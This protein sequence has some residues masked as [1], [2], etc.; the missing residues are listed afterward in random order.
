MTYSRIARALSIPRSV[1]NSVHEWIWSNGTI[2]IGTNYAA[3][4]LMCGGLA[5]YILR[6]FR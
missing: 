4:V 6:H 3:A 5:G 2:L 1:S